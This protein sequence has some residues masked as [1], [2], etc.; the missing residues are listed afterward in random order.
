MEVGIAAV[1][2]QVAAVGVHVAAMGIGIAVVGVGAATMGVIIACEVQTV[3]V[4]FSGV[5][6]DTIDTMHMWC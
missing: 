2:V 6:P 1:G 5:W 3:H 4:H